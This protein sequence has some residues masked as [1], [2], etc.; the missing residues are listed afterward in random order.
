MTTCSIE[1]NV[2][3]CWGAC[4][5]ASFG[6]GDVF[7]WILARGWADEFCDSGIKV[8]KL[9]GMLL[10]WCCS[11]DNTAAVLVVRHWSQEQIPESQQRIDGEI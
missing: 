9:L 1:I 4:V 10:S 6:Q 7:I 2:P 11:R 5:T 8:P 3:P